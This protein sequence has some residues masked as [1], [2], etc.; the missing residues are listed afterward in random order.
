MST[1][2]RSARPA[3]RA[4]PIAPARRKAFQAGSATKPLLEGV[5]DRLPSVLVPGDRGGVGEAGV[6][7][8]VVRALVAEDDGHHRAGAALRVVLPGPRVDEPLGRGDSV[9]PADD[10]HVAALGRA[11][12]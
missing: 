9:L 8:T 10:E 7:C 11:R 6:S 3:R 5:H 2:G 4:E 1:V 12:R